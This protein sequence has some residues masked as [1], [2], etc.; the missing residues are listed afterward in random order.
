MGRLGVK[1]SDFNIHVIPG[2]LD[3]KKKGNTTNWGKRPN[4]ND[5]NPD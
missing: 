1:P 5:Q 2:G 4:N 3:L